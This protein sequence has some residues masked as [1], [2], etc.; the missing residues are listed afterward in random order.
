V[1]VS[2]RNVDFVRD[3]YDLAIR[4][5]TI[6]DQAL[7]ARRLGVFPIGVFAS[8]AYLARRGRPKSLD[9]LASHDCITFVMPRTGRAMAW[10]FASPP[11][12]L[13]PLARHRV[14]ED[15]LGL[16]AMARAGLGLVQTYDFMVDEHVQRGELVEVL[17][18]HRGAG[19]PFSLVYPRSSRRSHAV[20]SFVDFVLAQ[21]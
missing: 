7:V 13:E 3:G 20:R 11:L 5:G 8:P 6:T 1:Q 17:T 4:L 15:V 10:E 14:T 2:N 9:E 19:R 21:K 12:K 18:E 16:V